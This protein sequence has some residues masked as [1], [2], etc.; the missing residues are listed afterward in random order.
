MAKEGSFI[1]QCQLYS[2]HKDSWVPRMWTMWSPTPESLSSGQWWEDKR[3]EIMSLV[4]KEE[5][6]RIAFCFLKQ[7]QLFPSGHRMLE[8]EWTSKITQ[9]TSFV[10]SGNRSSEKVWFS[11]YH[12][13]DDRARGRRPELFV[14]I[15]ASQWLHFW[16]A[17]MWPLPLLLTSRWV[18]QRNS[19]SFFSPQK[20]FSH[21]ALKL[22]SVFFSLLR[23]K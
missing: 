5:R 8:L 19:A 21:K 15:T 6:D 20:I 7:S 3:E 11:T 13:T 4:E 10:L 1:S 16:C 18:S 2:S 23:I 22:L 14:W 9:V 12:T 17:K